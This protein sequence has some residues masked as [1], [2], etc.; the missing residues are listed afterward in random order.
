MLGNNRDKYRRGMNVGASQKCGW[1]RARRTK[2]KCGVQPE[3]WLM[4]RIETTKGKCGSQSQVWLIDKK[5]KG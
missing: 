4:I 1:D 3:V 2:G 5:D